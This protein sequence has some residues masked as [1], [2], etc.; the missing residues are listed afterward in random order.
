MAKAEQFAQ[1]ATVVH[2]LAEEASDVADAYVTLCV[3][4]GIAAADV[5]CAARLGVHA[6][7]ERHDEAVALLATVDR[8]AA[9]HLGVLLGMKTAA[10][11]GHQPVNRERAVRAGRAM[12]ALIEAARAAG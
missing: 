10:G 6:Q 12:D 1:A 9:K 7:G 4:A 11:Y 3:H 2:E 8:G 5:I